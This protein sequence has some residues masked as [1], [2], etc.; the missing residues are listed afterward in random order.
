MISNVWKDLKNKQLKPAYLLLGKESYLIQET[1]QLIIEAALDP[2]EMDF[3]LAQYD[4]SETPLES[5]IEDAETLPFLGEKRVVILKNPQFLTSEK[6]K[7]KIEH[8]IEKLE[9]YLKS[10]APYTILV[11]VAPY[12]KLDE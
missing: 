3:N 1:V 8:R 2:S 5:A 9:E 12:E 7:E 4:L 6:K 10:P 11:I